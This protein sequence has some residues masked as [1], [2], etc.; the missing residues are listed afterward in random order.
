MKGKEVYVVGGGNS[1]GQAAVHLSRFAK[2][3]TILVRRGGLAET[4]S[5]YLIREISGNPRI[6][7]RPRTVVVDGE[8]EG[9]LE[10]LTLRDVDTADEERVDASGLYLL[11]GAQPMCDWL[12]REVARDEHGF[13]LSGAD[14][15][16]QS[17]QGGRP[18]A[19]YAT[20]VPGVFV[21]G[22]IRCN[23]MRRVASA[24]G[25]GAAAVPLV[26]AFLAQS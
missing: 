2:H 20:T 4:M 8:G 5:N 13:V 22:D 17:W 24:S 26:H 23:S 21:A 6:T 15:P 9:H 1:A 11:L 12:P 19:P 14:T 10:W 25:E 7:V 16:W 3:V 18:P